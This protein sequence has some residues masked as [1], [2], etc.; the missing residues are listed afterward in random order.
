MKRKNYSELER[1][2]NII[3]RAAR[4]Y[5]LQVNVDELYSKACDLIDENTIDYYVT[6]DDFDFDWHHLSW[7]DG[8]GMQNDVDGEFDDCTYMR[9]VN[10]G[11]MFVE[12]KKYEAVA[13]DY[14]LVYDDIDSEGQRVGFLVKISE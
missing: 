11:T 4:D 8:M 12:I 3:A 14:N 10:N 13:G 2:L 9:A 1:K 5:D 7:N 6:D